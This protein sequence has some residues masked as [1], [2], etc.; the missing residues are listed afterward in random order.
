MLYQTICTHFS[1][2]LND[3]HLNLSHARSKGL[4]VSAVAMATT[5]PKWTKIDILA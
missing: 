4:G 5:P 1:Y 3:S 2:A